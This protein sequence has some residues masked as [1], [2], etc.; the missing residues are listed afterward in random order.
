MDMQTY[1]ELALRTAPGGPP[2]NSAV[3]VDMQWLLGALGLCGESGEIAEIIKKHVFHGH[4]LDGETRS[5]LRKECG[6][7]LWYLN[8]LANLLDRNLGEIADLN[9][10]KLT[11]RYPKGTFSTERSIHRAVGDV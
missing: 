9:I 10:E 3:S 6:D 2:R 5:K 8:Y 7:V 4:P 1:Q 11:S